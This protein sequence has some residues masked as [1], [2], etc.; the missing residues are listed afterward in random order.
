MQMRNSG[1]ASSKPCTT[2]PEACPQ[3]WVAGAAL[4]RAKGAALL[5]AGRQGVKQRSTMCFQPQ[6]DSE[7]TTACFSKRS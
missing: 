4:L 6:A 7:A 5:A 3:L 1:V 2:L